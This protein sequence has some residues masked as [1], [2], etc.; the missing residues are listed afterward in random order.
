MNRHYREERWQ[1]TVNRI[2]GIVA[3]CTLYDGTG[4]EHT[5]TAWIGDFDGDEVRAGDDFE[6]L[7]RISGPFTWTTYQILPPREPT[8]EELAGI[9][10]KAAELREG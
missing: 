7:F 8:P 5:H 2:E 1:G 4:K 10:R 6:A 9:A 3:F